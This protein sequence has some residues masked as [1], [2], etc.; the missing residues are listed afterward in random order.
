MINKKL[1]VQFSGGLGNQMFQYATA[2][3]LS[4]ANNMELVLDN[5][6]G[7]VRDFQYSRSYALS[8]FNVEGRFPT[9]LEQ[10]P[11]WIQRVLQKTMF[12]DRKKLLHT[13]LFGYFL[14]EGS[15]LNGRR[16]YYSQLNTSPLLKS[17]WMD[18]YWQSDNYFSTIES[19][20][21]KELTPPDPTDSKVS[22]LGGRMQN[23]NSVAVCIRLYEESNNPLHH[24][25]DGVMKSSDIVRKVLDNILEKLNVDCFY[26]FCSHEADY[27]KELSEGIPTYFVTPENGYQSELDSLWLMSKCQ[28]HVITNSSFYWWGAWLAD[29]ANVDNNARLVYCADNF[30]NIDSIRKNWLTF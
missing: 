8:K 26:V 21:L 1:V 29:M 24:C 5:W 10:T 23:E 18:G 20:I 7:F 13:D 17:K 27:L 22:E 4:H 14:S 30:I 25:G 28:H 11:F 19:L 3:S 2:R 15:P 9:K 12:F 16:K 6:S